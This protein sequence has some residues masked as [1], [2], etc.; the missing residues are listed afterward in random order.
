M[1]Y[2]IEDAENLTTSVLNG[3]EQRMARQDRKAERTLAVKGA[4]YAAPFTKLLSEAYK[5]IQ[6]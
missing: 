3:L 5:N 2:Q 6:N 1:D 4:T